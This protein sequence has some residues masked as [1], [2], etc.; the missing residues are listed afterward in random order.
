MPDL[1]APEERPHPFVYFI[2][3]VNDSVQTVSILGRK[4]VL[5]DDN[6]EIVVVEGQGVVGETPRLEPRQR[7]SY[8][9]YHVIKSASQ[10]TGSF[11]GKT[12]DG[13]PIRVK[14][15][16]FTLKVPENK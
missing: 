14:I 9:S 7:F 5:N 11:F 1:D 10:V 6:G 3:I 12:A 2:S 15:P 13:A 4:W 16:V 8:N